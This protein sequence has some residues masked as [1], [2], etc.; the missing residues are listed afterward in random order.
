[1]RIAVSGATG[2]IGTYVLNELRK[3]DIEIIALS[4]NI[5]VLKNDLNKVVWKNLDIKSPPKDTFNFIGRPDC[6]INLAWGGLPNYKS[7]LHLDEE[8]PS[9]YSF[10]YSLI[11]QGLKKIFNTGTCFEYGMQ[12]GGLSVDAKT[13][14]ENPYGSAK[15]KLHRDIRKLHQDYQFKFIWAR[16][17][18]IY[19]N[20]QAESSLYSSLKTAV[21]SGQKV[22][23]MSG[24]E[25]LRDF[26]PVEEV[27]KNI[28]DLSLNNHSKD[29]INIC[30]G[31]PISVRNLVNEWVV[32]NNWD[33]ELLFGEYPYPDYEPHKFWG[34]K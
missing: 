6:L 32:K 12:S 15:D 24:G 23:K 27:A 16:L 19:G 33:I 3:R 25:Q 7:N 8:L 20:G 17:F 30:S 5:P 18:Y 22:F 9:Q 2:F 29:L 31:N 10:L 13:N 28:V 4:R 1:M 21:N 26:L 14:P 11:K 34:I